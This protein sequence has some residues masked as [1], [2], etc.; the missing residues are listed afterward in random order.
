MK[1]AQTDADELIAAYRLEQQE[2][3][4]KASSVDGKKFLVM[5]RPYLNTTNLSPTHK[6]LFHLIPRRIGQRCLGETSSRNNQRH[7]GNAGAIH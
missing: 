3:F 4:D 5:S 6:I 2:A 1:Q 7:S